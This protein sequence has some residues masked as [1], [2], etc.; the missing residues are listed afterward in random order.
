MT[1]VSAMPDVGALSGSFLATDV[2]MSIEVISEVLFFPLAVF[3][4]QEESSSELVP[5]KCSV[6]LD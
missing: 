6:F 4:D 2:V 3:R 5:G 1:V